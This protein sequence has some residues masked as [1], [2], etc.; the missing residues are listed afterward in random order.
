MLP[1]KGFWSYVREDEKATGNRI[2]RLA[3]DIKNEFDLNR[4]EE[5]LE[6]FIDKKEIKWGE[7][8]KI[9][10]EENI[11]AIGFLIAVITPRFFISASCREELEYFFEKT[12]QLENQKILLPLLYV[13]VPELHEKEESKDE[14]I[15]QIK[16]HQWFDATELRLIDND[17][18][19]YRKIV[20]QIV[21]KLIEANK[22]QERKSVMIPEKIQ[23]EIINDSVEGKGMIDTLAEYERVLPEINI[24][25]ESLTQEMKEI[26]RIG[27]DKIEKMSQPKN[28]SFSAR[29]R[30]LIEAAAEYDHSTENIRLYVGQFTKQMNILDSS[31]SI[32][33]ENIPKQIEDK[34]LKESDARKL[35]QQISTF[36]QAISESKKSIQYMSDSMEPLEKLSRDIRPVMRAMRKEFAILIDSMGKAASWEFMIQKTNI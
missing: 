1:L 2:T 32:I 34:S 5:E 8:W 35:F 36:V 29:Q 31:L 27:K 20:N 26:T 30:L 7:E 3:E 10:I 25:I 19:A 28:K 18:S 17:S 24:T 15:E 11:T 13:D 33:I 14:L 22:E 6:I 23:H 21:I 16:K 12:K 9:K 4:P